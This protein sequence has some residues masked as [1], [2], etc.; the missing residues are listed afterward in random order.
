VIIDVPAYK[1]VTKP[2]REPIDNTV[3]LVDQFPPVVASV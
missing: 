3:V 2:E 1:P